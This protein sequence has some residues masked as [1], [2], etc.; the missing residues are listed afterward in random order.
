[1]DKKA[2][3]R[4][5][6]SGAPVD[7]PPIAFWGHD[8]FREWS[9]RELAAYTVER[10]RRYDDDFIKL[11]PRATY[12][13]EAWGNTY[14]RPDTPRQPRLLSHAV[15]TPEQFAA[16]PEIDPTTGPFGEQLEAL[17][18]IVQE[19]G[20]EVDIVQTVFNPLTVAS[21]LLGA[22]GEPFK[23]MAR[24]DPAAAHTGLATIARVLARYGAACI[25]TGAAGIFFATVDWA[26]ATAADEAFYREFGRPYDLQVLQAVRGAPFNILHVCRDHNFLRLLLDYPVTAFHWDVHGAGNAS[27]AEGLALTDRAVMGGIDRRALARSTDRAALAAQVE[28]ALRATGGRRLILAGG[29]SIDPEAPEANLRAVIEAARAAPAA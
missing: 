15:D 9:P 24:R 8:F 5:A 25:A 17:R 27:L 6:L 13:A 1:V 12:Y 7:R 23:A 11:N 19:V 16:L 10:Y 20:Q 26:T 18:L 4:A 14:D 3:I 28:E 29:C 21:R 22:D 2:R